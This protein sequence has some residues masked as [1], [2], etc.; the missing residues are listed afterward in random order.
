M[1]II[2]AFIM[3]A[4]LLGG[5]ASFFESDK[6]RFESECARHG[7][8]YGT[9]HMAQCVESKSRERKVRQENYYR[10]AEEHWEAGLLMME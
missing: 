7:Q 3:S 8:R 5:C 2:A 6:A 9:P 1:K 4:V 10:R